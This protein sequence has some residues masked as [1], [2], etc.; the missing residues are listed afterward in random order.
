MKLVL[1]I[2]ILPTHEQRVLLLKTIEEANK[3]CAYISG[4]AWENRVFSQFKI[5]HLCYEE[6]RKKFGLS[7]QMVV[8][9][10]G[11]VADAYKLDRKKKRDF[12]SHGSICYDSRILS[13]NESGISIWTVGKRQKIP[14]VCHAKER[15]SYAKG[16]A[17]LVFRKDKFYLYQTIDIAEPELQ[18]CN[19]VIGLDFGI[20]DIVCTSEGKTYSSDALN[21][22]REKRLKIRGSIQSKGTRG[23]KKLLKRLSG[24]E[25]TTATIINH[26]ISKEIVSD[27]K[28][29]GMGLSVED[30]RKIRQTSSQRNKAFR[31]KL[32]CWN[33]GQLRSFITYKCI[34]SG[35]R[36]VIVNPSYTS[37]TCSYCHHIGIR[38]GKSFK[39][40]NCGS[41]I[42]ADV[43]A[44]RNIAQLG[45]VVNQPEKSDMYSCLLHRA[46]Q[47]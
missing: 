4:I 5:H 1:K 28:K 20:K 11:K 24:R 6:V 29:R 12:E 10:I 47:I 3:A 26:T 27:A 43:N 34:L 33:Y 16:E 42:D 25:R 44:A 7:A 35:V 23:C 21:E 40:T 41:D 17:D 14:F 39:C 46:V 45:V 38:R 9:C 32:N 37:Q 13:Y 19:D 31:S 2:K 8:R 15:M 30:L 22:Y 18:G 36:L